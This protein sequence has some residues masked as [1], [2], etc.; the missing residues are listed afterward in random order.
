MF[1]FTGPRYSNSFWQ[2]IIQTKIFN[3]FSPIYSYIISCLEEMLYIDAMMGVTDS[4]ALV[5]LVIESF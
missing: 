1:V 3:F 2:I 5:I 4:E